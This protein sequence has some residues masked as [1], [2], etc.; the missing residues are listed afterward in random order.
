MC[1][2][3]RSRRR[4]TKQPVYEARVSLER[5]YYKVAE[6]KYPLRY[7]MMA[8]VEIVVRERRLIDLAVGPVPAGRRL[9]AK[10]A[11]PSNNK[12]RMR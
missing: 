2:R 1:R 3:P 9:S 5:D 8:T 11:D 12:E 6:T 4:Q 10:H 7:G